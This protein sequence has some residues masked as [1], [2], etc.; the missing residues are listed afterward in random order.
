MDALEKI[1]SI[2][3]GLDRPMSDVAIAWLL[4]RP[5]V[6]SVLVGASRPDQVARNVRAASLELSKETIA[7]LDAATDP[8]REKLGPSLDQWADPPRTR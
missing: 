3:D 2:A 4:A 1:R 5:S 7:A 8:V 6:A